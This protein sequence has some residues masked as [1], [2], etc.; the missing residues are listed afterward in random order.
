LA[1]ARRTGRAARSR[2]AKVLE[3]D[4]PDLPLEGVRDVTRLLA[5]TIN[6]VRKGQLD[7]KIANTVGYLAGIMLRSFEVGELEDRLS[8]LEGAINAETPWEQVDLDQPLIGP[9]RTG[10]GTGRSR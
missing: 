3:P 8:R 1:E 4:E 7:P 6:R 9:A 2:P 10:P 5:D